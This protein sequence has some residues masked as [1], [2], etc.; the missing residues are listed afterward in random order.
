MSDKGITLAV[1][2][3]RGRM[4]RLVLSQALADKRFRLLEA[5]VRRDDAVVGQPVEGTDV[6]YSVFD[7]S[8]RADVIVN[9]G[10]ADGLAS[11]LSKLDENVPCALVSGST[12]FDASIEASLER[13]AQRRPVFSAENFSVGVALMEALTHQL[14]QIAPAGFDFEI[15][16]AHHRHKKDAPSGTALRLSRAVRK[17]RELNEKTVRHGR[18][19][20]DELGISAIRGGDIVGEHTVYALANGERIELTHRAQSRAIFA[21]GALEAAYWLAGREPGLYGMQDLLAKSLSA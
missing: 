19:E 20:Q 2:G 14:A 18:R 7:G 13:T 4:G 1:F 9:F 8:S 16:E 17:A 5:F 21:A 3:A 6:F 11:L 12:G 10:D 15:S